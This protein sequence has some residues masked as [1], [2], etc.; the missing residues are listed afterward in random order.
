MRYEKR[1]EFVRL[2]ND[3]ERRRLA[4]TRMYL[5]SDSWCEFELKPRAAGTFPK[6]RIMSRHWWD[7]VFRNN[8]WNPYSVGMCLPLCL[9]YALVAVFSLMKYSPLAAIVS[10]F[11]IT[12]AGALLTAYFPGWVNSVRRDEDKIVDEANGF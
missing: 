11:V 2:K 10:G 12:T 1:D 6:F 5:E 7:Y 8:R 3:L 4:V 9:G